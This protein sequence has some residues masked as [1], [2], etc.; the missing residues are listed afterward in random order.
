MN[1]SIKGVP[2]FRCKNESEFMKFMRELQS[3][4]NFRMFMA[5]AIP[6]N[7][8]KLLMNGGADLDTDTIKAALVMTNTTVDTEV[9]A[10]TF[11][12]QYTTL[13]ECDATGYARVTLG[14]KTVT[15]DDTGN[16]GVFDA[17]DA[18]FTGLS[19]DA[20]RATQGALVL[21]FVTNDTDSPPLFFV[22]FASTTPATATQVDIPW[23]ATGILLLS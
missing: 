3:K 23:S 11:V 17:A 9:D 1:K 6:N 16:T 22:E 7:A 5:S 21:K 8:K 4:D 12:N 15:A 10:M 13:D 2:R 20:T 19:G 14:T 18:S